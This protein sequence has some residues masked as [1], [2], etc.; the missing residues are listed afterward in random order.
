MSGKSATQS[1]PSKKQQK[2]R[3]GMC[4]QDRP[5]L[6]ENAAG[7]DVGAREMFVTVAPDWDQHPVR[8]FDTF[9]AELQ[10]LAEWLVQCGIKPVAMESTGVYWIPLYD[11]L[12][13]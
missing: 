5:I 13:E 10:Q 2:R 11:I 7:I 3:K 8:V 12:E 9:T 1:Q 6:E 4:E